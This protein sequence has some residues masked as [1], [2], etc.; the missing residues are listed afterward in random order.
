MQDVGAHDRDQ[1]DRRGRRDH[2]GAAPERGR[3]RGPEI[4]GGLSYALEEVERLRREHLG[5]GID[6]AP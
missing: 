2:G 5:K 1:P 6:S 4:E 3:T